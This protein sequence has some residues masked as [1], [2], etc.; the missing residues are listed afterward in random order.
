LKSEFSNTDPEI[1]QVCEE[2]R[3]LI[4]ESLKE[5]ID[6]RRVA[7]PPDLDLLT[8]NISISEAAFQNVL[9]EIE[10]KEKIN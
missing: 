8:Q 2:A 7:M 3:I 6:A 5:I 4:K 10:S 1:A 9:K